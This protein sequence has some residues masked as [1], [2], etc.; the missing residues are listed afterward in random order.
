MRRTALMV[1]VCVGVLAAPPWEIAC[2]QPGKARLD[3]FGDPLPQQ[4]L[5]RLGTVRLRQGY[6]LRALKF[7]P[8]G[9]T[10]ISADTGGGI[11]VWNSADGRLLHAYQADPGVYMLTTIAVSPDGTLLAAYGLRG[12]ITL[13]E[14][15]S[16]KVRH[17][18]KDEAEY[19]TCLQFSPDNETLAA[20]RSDGKVGAWDVVTGKMTRLFARDKSKVFALYFSADNKNL[21]A[22][23][24]GNVLHTWDL[25][26]GKTLAERPGDKGQ[27]FKAEFSPDGK[28]AAVQQG[29][30]T[31]R[32]LDVASGAEVFDLP[33]HKTRQSSPGFALAFGPDGRKLATLTD[34]GELRLWDLTTGKLIHLFSDSEWFWHAGVAFSPDGTSLASFH[35]FRVRLWDVASGK[36][37]LPSESPDGCVNALAFSAD[38]KTLATS[39][40]CENV[41]HLWDTARGRHLRILRGHTWSMHTVAFRP[42]GKILATGSGD[43][44]VRLWDPVTGKLLSTQWGHTDPVTAL[45]FSSDGTLLASGSEDGTIR[46]RDGATGKTLQVW[47]ELA[48]V[49]D[50]LCFSPNGKTLVSVSNYSHGERATRLWNVPSG[51]SER[52]EE[53]DG[54]RG[55]T[56]A[57]FSPDGRLLITSGVW[58]NGSRELNHY[59]LRVYEVATRQMI[60]KYEG[61]D[62]AEA[63]FIGAL[64]VAPDGRTLI[65][66]HFRSVRF[67]DLL[68]GKERRRLTGHH[69][70][71]ASLALSR[72]GRVLA[73]SSF[74]TTVLLWDLPALLVRERP[75]PL[76]LSRKEL[77]ASWSALAERDSAV[78]YK[79]LHRL[80]MAG[81][82]AVAWL[83]EHLRPVPPL[84]DEAAVVKHLDALD[85]PSFAT[86]TNAA[87]ALAAGGE[88]VVPL[89][90]ARLKNNV[91]LE[92]HR[93]LEQL[94]AKLDVGD[95]APDRL[96]TLR[97]VTVLELA[98]TTAA[99]N[100]LQK[101]ASGA[102]QARLTQE[103]QA[104]LGRSAQERLKEL[105]GR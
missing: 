2:G 17:R 83:E 105:S 86:R 78:G 12:V 98:G 14:I 39:S 48:V 68:T 33:G 58:D 73:T 93:R 34:A 97:A 62:P 1:L 53:E 11:R 16:G 95:A 55:G 8:D 65:S 32:V 13:F 25:A 5:A 26:T 77:Q 20:A 31:F 29:G 18:L 88:L 76:Q 24:D 94:L 99:Q 45:A 40:W 63:K 36:E 80:T 54:Y 57:V 66:T 101:L 4:A 15:P 75:P 47:K 85:D 41:A 69:G 3:N 52:L 71:L 67:W 104:A 81:D 84:L 102:A 38:G 79:H 7:A 19:V 44:S 100:L 90:K 22:W 37:R 92:T 87:A 91:T 21:S 23:T 30:K 59:W 56:A 72:D 10:L 42:D 96:R 50:S 82:Q 64:A 60:W 35:H 51:K 46:I 9:E 49:P 70:P 28:R 43:R 89:L 61:Q 27:V 103:A 6:Y 74:D